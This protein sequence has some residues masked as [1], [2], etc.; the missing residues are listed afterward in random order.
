[1]PEAQLLP[2]D[3]RRASWAH[4][5]RRNAGFLASLVVLA[6]G[7][8]ILDLILPGTIDGLGIRPRTLGGIFGIAFAPFLHQGFGHLASNTLP[9]LF[10]G[11]VV[12]IGGRALFIRVSLII[13]ALSGAALWTLGPG[14]TNHIGA[15]MLIFGYLG[16]L[17][18]RGFVERSPVWTTISIAV[19]L[20]YGGM[21]NGVLP[22]QPGVSWQGHLFGFLSG[23]LAAR[24]H[25]SPPAVGAGT[26][27]R[28][29]GAGLRG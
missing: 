13:A 12:L 15:S 1:M 17:V 23:I 25:F 2:N 29:T 14:K 27:F 6:W 18:A 28:E 20:L 16:F 21:I 10:L 5:L 26:R 4:A 8:E 24:I 22:G 9:F 3:H 11:G 7:L 19:L